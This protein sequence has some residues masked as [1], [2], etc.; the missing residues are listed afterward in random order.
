MPVLTKEGFYNIMKNYLGYRNQYAGYWFVG[1]EENW[2]KI[3]KKIKGGKIELTN[4]EFNYYNNPISGYNNYMKYTFE[5]RLKSPYRTFEKGIMEIYKRLEKNND[6]QNLL[7]NCFI[8][9]INF[10][11]FTIDLYNYYQKDKYLNDLSI[12]I[13]K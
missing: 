8:W 7:S 2:G 6:V 3:N 12:R 5:C 10:L 1:K 13:K 9:N 11:P 4:E